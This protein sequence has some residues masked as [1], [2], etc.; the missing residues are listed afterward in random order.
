MPKAAKEGPAYL[1]WRGTNYTIYGER[2]KGFIAQAAE[3]EP[4]LKK[5]EAS[6]TLEEL[7]SAI[8]RLVAAYSEAKSIIRHSIA[9]S[10]GSAPWDG[11]SDFCCYVVKQYYPSIGC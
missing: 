8:E 7:L 6:G 3:A 10:G 9:T 2:L 5:A 1:Q 11:L 4:Q